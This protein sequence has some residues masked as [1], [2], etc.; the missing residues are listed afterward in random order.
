MTVNGW[1]QIALFAVDRDR[2]YPPLGGY[3]T[4]V[5]NG[6]RTL[7]LAAC[8]ARSSAAL[9]HLRRRREGRAALAGLHR[10]HAAVQLAG[11]VM[12]Y[13]L[14]RLQAVLPFNPAGQTAVAASIWPSIPRSASSPTPTGSPTRR[15]THHE[16]SRPDGRPDGAQFPVGGDRH[17]AG[18]GA[19]PR[20]RAA[21]GQDG[22]QFLG[23]YHPLHALRA[24][25]G[26]HRRRRCS[27]SGRACRRTSAPISTR[28]RWK[29]PS[30]LIAQGPV[31]SQEVIK[32][33]GT[34]GGGFFNANSAHPFE[35]PDRADQFRPDGAD[36]LDRRGADQRV[37][38]HG[39]QT[40]ARAGRS[41][42]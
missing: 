38:P 29:A 3:M 17:R 18:D 4:R 12:L 40:S 20:L 11:F 42:P 22:R 26:L 1:I 36:L 32:M 35:N 33:F 37:R 14:Q 8:C 5:F 6:E 28:R 2:A 34:N 31:A 23:R 39:R 24:A 9:P 25:A 30:R 10:R 21:L 41:S 7:L 13:A 27:S 19:G 16:L 15:E